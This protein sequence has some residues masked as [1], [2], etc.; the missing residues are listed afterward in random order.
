MIKAASDAAHDVMIGD[1]WVAPVTD[2]SRVND[3]ANTIIV[4]DPWLPMDNSS[5]DSVNDIIVGDPWRPMGSNDGINNEI[6]IGD[7]W[8]VTTKKGT[9]GSGG[10]PATVAKFNPGLGSQQI[11]AEVNAKLDSRMRSKLNSWM[12]AEQ[13]AGKCKS[14][15]RRVNPKVEV[16]QFGIS[17]FSKRSQ[18]INFNQG[19]SA[20]SF[21]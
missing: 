19:L 13:Q 18:G 3:E 17:V 10:A 9:D 15:N 14:V 1:P 8:V 12:K 21:R 5:Q 16:P 2:G 7:P 6:I 20:I 4:G 11:K